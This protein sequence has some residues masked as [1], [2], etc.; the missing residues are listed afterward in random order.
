MGGAEKLLIQIL[1]LMQKNDVLADVLILKKNNTFYERYLEKLGIKVFFLSEKRSVYNILNICKIRPFMHNYDIV[2]THLFPAQYWTILSSYFMRSRPFFITTEH[3]TFNQRRSKLWIYVERYIFG[4]YTRIISI[5]YKTQH[6]MNKFLKLDNYLFRVIENGVDINAFANATAIEVEDL[7][8]AFF[9]KDDIMIIMIARFEKAK[10]HFTLLRAL[11]RLP[12][13]YK[14]IL[15][16]DGIL[17]ATAESQCRDLGIESRV[18][19]LGQRNDVPKILKAAKIC[20]VSSNW[21][22]FGLVAIE[23]MAAG[24]PVIASDVDGLNDIVKDA[25]LLFPKGDDYSL[26]EKIRELAED[27]VC[28][29]KIISKQKRRV[30]VY[31]IERCADEYLKLY[32]EVIDDKTKDN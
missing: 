30:K 27:E 10:D 23:A 1:P 8:Q 17:K 3:S 29:T 26:S 25:G 18:L 9:R 24:V 14:L 13:K 12:E 22:G 20:I 4:R 11:S 15:V 7:S 2:H 21:E 16:G 28:R 6:L 32:K 31:S 5:S 19:F